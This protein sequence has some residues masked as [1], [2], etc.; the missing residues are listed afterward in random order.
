MAQNRLGIKMFGILWICF[1]IINLFTYIF[2]LYPNIKGTYAPWTTPIFA[3]LFIL[4]G[5]GILILRNWARLGII[6][7]STY[8]GVATSLRTFIW[9]KRFSESNKANSII[10]TAILILLFYISVIYYFMRPQIKELF[11]DK[12]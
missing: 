11:K 6:F 10:I 3:L 4:V 9:F 1:G 7:L 8:F 12:E 5:I 2:K